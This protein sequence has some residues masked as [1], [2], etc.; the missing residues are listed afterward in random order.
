M[1]LVLAV[2]ATS[3][4][5][6][7]GTEDTVNW[8]KKIHVLGNENAY[9]AAFDGGNVY[10]VGYGRNLAGPTGQDGWMKKFNSNGV[11]NITHWNKNYTGPDGGSD[12]ARSVAVDGNHDVYVVGYGQALVTGSSSDDWWVKKFSAS[13]VE[14]A[15]WNKT[16]TGTPTGSDYA[17]SVA[18]DSNDNA[19]VVGYGNNLVNSTSGFDWW[20]KKFDRN[21]VE[22]TTAWNKTIT[23][24]TSSTTDV[25]SFVAVDGNDNIYVVGYA[26]K[27]SSST[28]NTDMW[29]KKFDSSGVEDTTN[30]NK[31]F[32]GTS[33]GNDQ[34]QSVAFDANNNVYV[35]GFGQNLVNSTSGYDWWIKK[36]D[37]N[38]VENITHWNKTVTS[39]ISGG[40]DMAN[41][42][43]V[44]SNNNV[45]VVGYGAQLVSSSPS[46]SEDWWIKKFD[47]NGVENTTNWNKNYTGTSTGSDVAYSVAVDEYNNVYVVGIGTNIVNGGSGQDWWIKK[48]EGSALRVQLSASSFG[49]GTTNFTLVPDLFDVRNMTLATTNT[50]VRWTGTV[51]ASGKDFDTQVKMESLLL[52]INVSALGQGFNSTAVVNMSG[53]NCAYFNLY[54]AAGFHANV[55][56]L[57]SAGTRV[58]TKVNRGG[59]CI[60]PTICTDITCTNGVLTFTAQHFDGFGGDTG[61]T[62]PIPEFGTWALLLA[63]GLVAGGIVSMR[64]K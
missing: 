17:L 13:G 27:L 51:N 62:P 36:F 35:V 18:V 9:S 57:I 23:A 25:A 52:S 26:Q 58:A 22:N 45:F 40:V 3:V 46:S 30:W 47:S 42:F 19:Y 38:G 24:P 61:P 4:L 44:D 49:Q 37:N 60:D 7:E 10:V 16:F 59:N 20:I 6:A 15:S 43:A 64:K 31:N 34:A 28:S 54:Y 32:T 12:F 5:A 14:Y 2:L 41:S 48:F 63:L 56:S 39:Q 8:N 29:I 53:I 1:V 50:S 11:E 21:G 33:T 55:S